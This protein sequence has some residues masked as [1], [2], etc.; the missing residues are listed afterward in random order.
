[1]FQKFNLNFHTVQTRGKNNILK[2]SCNFHD[3]HIL[4]QM[5]ISKHNLK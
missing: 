3:A 4:N 2:A 1:M 5:L